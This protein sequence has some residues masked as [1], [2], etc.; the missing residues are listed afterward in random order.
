LTGVGGPLIF[1]EENRNKARENDDATLVDNDIVDSG[2]TA[3]LK[4]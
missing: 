1:E 4:L 3:G 2:L